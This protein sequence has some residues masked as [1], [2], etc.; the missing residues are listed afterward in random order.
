MYLSCTISV[1][2]SLLSQNLKKSRD[3]EHIPFG[4]NLSY[5]YQSA[6]KICLVEKLKVE[7]WQKPSFT[8]SKDIWGAKLKKVASDNDHASVVIKLKQLWGPLPPR[9]T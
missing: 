2:L 3:D 8:D 9:S 1:I 7:N 4:C 5:L 6:H